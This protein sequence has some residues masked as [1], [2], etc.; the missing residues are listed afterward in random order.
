MSGRAVVYESRCMDSGQGA[1]I[2]EHREA[3]ALDALRKTHTHV[4]IYVYI[5]IYIY[6]YTYPSLSYIYIYIYTHA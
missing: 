2:A 6:I 4:C 5:Y 1:S 3:C